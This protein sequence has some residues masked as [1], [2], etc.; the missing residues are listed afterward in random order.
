MRLLILESTLGH[1]GKIIKPLD[2]SRSLVSSEMSLF[3][4]YW[5]AHGYEASNIRDFSRVALNI[6]TH[7]VSFALTLGEPSDETREKIK[8]DQWIKKDSKT[9]K[10]RAQH[11]IILDVEYDDGLAHLSDLERLERYIQ[12]LPDYYHESSYHYQFSSSHRLKTARDPEG[13]KLRVHLF[14]WAAKPI[15]V[16][17]LK[18]HL[19]GLNKEHHK[20]LIDTSPANH[21]GALIMSRPTFKRGVSDPIQQRSGLIIKGSD[22]VQLPDEAYKREL[23]RSTR[24]LSYIPRGFIEE[25]PWARGQLDNVCGRATALQDGRNTQL[26]SDAKWLGQIVGAE[27]LD[28]HE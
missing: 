8:R 6:E 16:D 23:A 20:K 13:S 10:D 18:R 28:E 12:L 7:R 21:S 2:G 4:S 17:Q 27:M 26:F 25:N 11:L 1:Y 19:E 5:K 14:F 22:E 15:R 3:P 9:I 24:P